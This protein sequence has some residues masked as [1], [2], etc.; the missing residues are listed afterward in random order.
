MKKKASV[1]KPSEILDIEKSWNFKIIDVNNKESVPKGGVRNTF[2][3][4][5][6]GD[7]ISL[8]LFELDIKDHSKLSNFKHL[9]RLSLTRC[10]VT[11]L[12]FLKENSKLEELFLGGNHILYIENLSN[13]NKL[14][15][16]AIWNNP[17]VDIQS[18]STIK[19]LESLFCQDINLEN[20]EFLSHLSNLKTLNLSNNRIVDISIINTLKKLKQLSCANNFIHS[21]EPLDNLNEL[22]KLDL[23]H[24]LIKNIPHS[25]AAK[26]NWLEDAVSESRRRTSFSVDE[27]EE[28]SIEISL[29]ENPLEFPP[30]SVIELGPETVEN[31]YENSKLFGYSPLSEG[32]IIVVG[33]GSAGKSSLIEKILYG[34]FELGKSQT[35]GIKIEKWKLSHKDKRELVFNI[36]D[37]GG[38]EI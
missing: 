5:D 38:Q 6:T 33:D 13:L 35:N 34:T 9:T 27:D 8:M 37:F 22:K 16:L 28:L 2:E 17:I 20:I 36:W 23:N 1:T 14:L 30:N 29:H 10:N 32:R 26:F 25:L 24:N 7:V 12:A 19:T 21:I 15:Q 18:I 4:N 31:Y 11:D 3:M